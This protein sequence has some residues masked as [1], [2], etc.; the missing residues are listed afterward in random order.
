MEDEKAD[1]ARIFAT[2]GTIVV[3]GAEGLPFAINMPDGRA[4]SAGICTER[5]EVPVMSGVYMVKVGHRT[6]KVFV[7]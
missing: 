4:V 5:T 3:T 1:R 2:E 7:K 6:V